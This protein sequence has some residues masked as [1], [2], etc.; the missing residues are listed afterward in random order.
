[1]AIESIQLRAQAKTLGIEGYRKMSIAE[2]TAAIKS[3][4]GTATNPVKTAGSKNGAAA[5]KPVKGSARKTA[6]KTVAKVKAAVKKTAAKPA[7]KKSTV[8]KSSVKTTPATSK[9]KS[10]TAKRSA[11][12]A[13]KVKAGQPGRVLIDNSEIDWTA[14]SRVGQSPGNRQTIL[15]LLRKHKGNVAKVKAVLNDKAQSMYGK[16]DDGKRRT[17]GAAIA[18]LSWHISRIKFDFVKD[19]GQHNGVVR[20]KTAKKTTVGRKTAAAKKTTAKRAPAKKAAT[21]KAV[22]KRAPAKKKT[23]AARKRK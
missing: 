23:A 12:G 5:D 8:R 17:K 2:L 14:E 20:A 18:L 11:S 6:K 22:V 4:K 10:G 9:K 1:M 16:T 3:A 13:G 19:T 21:R 7:P 15:K